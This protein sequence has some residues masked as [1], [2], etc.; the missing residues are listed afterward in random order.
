M[1]GAKAMKRLTCL[2][3]FLLNDKA[4]NPC[5]VPSFVWD[6]ND[7]RHHERR[8]RGCLGTPCEKPIYVRDGAPEILS[9]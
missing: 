7:L 9:M 6:V 3:N 2:H 8:N 1:A 4:E 5:A